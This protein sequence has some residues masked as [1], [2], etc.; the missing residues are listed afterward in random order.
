M[1]PTMINKN[2]DNAEKC[3]AIDLWNML[4]DEKRNNNLK[5]QFLEEEDED[6]SHHLI[7]KI[8]HRLGTTKTS[9]VKLFLAI[10]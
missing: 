7:A 1:W 8:S 6:V 2:N 9:K 5:I 10:L 4:S 3:V